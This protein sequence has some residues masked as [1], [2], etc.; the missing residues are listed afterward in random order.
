MC[1]K[2]QAIPPIPKSTVVVARA[3][4]PK[5]NRY[6]SLRDKFGSIF[7]DDQFEQLYPPQGQPA[8]SPWRLAL[9]CVMQYMENLT[10]RQTADAVRGRIDWKYALSLELTDSGF[11]FSVLSG[12]RDRLRIHKSGEDL[13]NHLLSVFN[14]D[15]LLKSRGNQ[16]TDSTHILSAVR[17]INRLELVGE[18]LRH[19]L[20]ELAKSYPTWLREHLQPE[21]LQR[22][23]DRVDD[24]RLPKGKQA[25]LD[26][27]ETIGRDGQQLMEALQDAST[28]PDLKHIPAVMT[29]RA[30]WIQEFYWEK[31]ELR[32]RKDNARPPSNQLIQS[33]YDLEARYSMKRGFTWIG[34]KLH[35]TETCDED[36]PH[37]IVHVETTKATTPDQN[38]LPPIH[39]SLAQRNL[40]PEAQYV[41]AGYTDLDSIVTLSDDYQVEVVGPLQPRS[42]WQAKANQGYDNDYF[43]FDWDTKTTTC[44]QGKTTTY[45]KELVSR[46]QTWIQARFHKHDCLTCTVRSLC[47]RSKE[48][49][50]Y[51][52]IR[53]DH[54]RI[55]V[56]RQQQNTDEWKER[57]K[58]RS[59]IEGTISQSLR[60]TDLRQARYIGLQ[61]THLQHFFS[62]MAINL[63]RIHAWMIEKPRCTKRQSPFQKLYQDAA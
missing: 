38:M 47:T 44:P 32:W 41:D 15:G 50:R 46:G 27:A 14:E 4:F 39:A 56:I 34:Y 51:V 53:P 28:S 30:I 37:L 59:G 13:F 58:L 48:D 35:L 7:T 29:L 40:L 57:Y 33:P 22:Y 19:T 10:D 23:G 43:I 2:P 6:M 12:F 49:P 62:A 45:W 5:E 18:T 8:Y 25:R 63:I 11:D 17:D 55:K 1:L 24:Y 26:L 20:N 60:V 16:R 52:R 54:D 3:A 21:W 9:I 36:Q 31:D 61:K 42:S